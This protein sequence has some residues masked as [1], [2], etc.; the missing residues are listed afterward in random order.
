A[1]RAAGRPTIALPLITGA[2]WSDARSG[3]RRG[4]RKTAS[5]RAPVWEEPRRTDFDE[6]GRREPPCDAACLTGTESRFSSPGNAGEMRAAGV[7]S[8]FL[9][10][11]SGSG[12]HRPCV[13]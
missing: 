2:L 1:R 13:R 7:R 4:M 8:E 10:P 5:S 3:T 6:E 9:E 12:V 11:A